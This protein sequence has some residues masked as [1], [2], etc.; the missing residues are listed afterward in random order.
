[1]KKPTRADL[2]KRIAELSRRNSELEGENQGLKIAVGVLK[3]ILTP[4]ESHVAAPPPPHIPEWIWRPPGF[5]TVTTCSRYAP[6][7]AGCAGNPMLGTFWVGETRPLEALGAVTI[8]ANPDPFFGT[9]TSLV[10]GGPQRPSDGLRF[11][12]SP[13]H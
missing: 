11:T 5:E 13:T 8:P 3:S 6:G 9:R 12:G 7:A 4:K 1:M 10:I 2:E